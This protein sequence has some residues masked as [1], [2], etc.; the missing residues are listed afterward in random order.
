MYIGENSMDK[1]MMKAL[2]TAAGAGITMLSCIGG[3]VWIGYEIDRYF[4][5][6]P[7][8]MFILGIIGA[9]TGMYMMYKQVK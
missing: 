2:A 5:S 4:H 8:C 3:F 9:T 7:T 1:E 6:E